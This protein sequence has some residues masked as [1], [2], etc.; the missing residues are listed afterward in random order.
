MNGKT[1]TFRA[2]AVAVLAVGSAMAVGCGGLQDGFQRVNNN[3]SW[4][5]RN[6]YHARQAVLHPFEVQQ[7]NAAVVN[8][9]V[10]NDHF[11]SGSDK[12]NGVGQDKLNQ[13]ARKMPAP[14]PTVYLQAA[15]DVAFDEKA[16]EKTVV[17]RTE[18]DQKRAAAVLAYLNTRPAPRGT[19]FTVQVIDVG[20]TSVNS[21]GPA[22]AVR[23]LQQ[24]YRSGI[25]GGI[26]GGNPAGSGGGIATNTVGVSP[27]AAGPNPSGGG[28]TSGGS[29]GGSGSGTGTGSGQ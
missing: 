13:L 7:N 16:P 1:R 14:N 21:V 11:D 27:S 8:D 29:G 4:P 17:G 18:L 3:N 10:L 15:N 9:V 28:G 24:Q 6:S 20:N 25:S 2:A 26:S 5:E 22:A 23:G 12:L 19:A